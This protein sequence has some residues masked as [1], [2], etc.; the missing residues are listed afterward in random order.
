[1]TPVRLAFIGVGDV[2]ERDYL[3][4]WD[5][6][7]ARAE[8]SV[9]CGRDEKR[10]RRVAE[11]YRALR[12]STDYLEVVRGDKTAKPVIATAMQLAKKIGLGKSPAKP[13]S[14]AKPAA[15]RGRPRKAG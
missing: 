3:A 4:E 8:I 2:A 12:W 14:A 10:V 15:R 1:M 5:R 7:S 6:L 13:A 11:K 9:V